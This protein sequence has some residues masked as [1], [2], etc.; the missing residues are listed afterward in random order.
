VP[1]PESGKKVSG[2]TPLRVGVFGKPTPA[3]ETSTIPATAKKRHGEQ[4]GCVYG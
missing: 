2:P 4:S 1:Y 3:S